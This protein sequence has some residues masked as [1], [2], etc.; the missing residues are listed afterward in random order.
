MGMRVRNR[1]GDYE[2]VHEKTE[3]SYRVKGE[4][5]KTKKAEERLRVIEEIS[6]YREEKIRREMARLE[7]E[8]AEEE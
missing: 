3:L 5:D 8:L 1:R 6:K 4:S 2:T 7:E